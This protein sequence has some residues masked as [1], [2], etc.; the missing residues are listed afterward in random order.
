MY[1]CHCN[2]VTDRTVDAAIASGASTVPDITDRCTAGGG[3]GGC[4]RL[5]EELLEAS[6][7][8]YELAAASAA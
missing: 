6:A 2:G 5:L 8:K 4:H 7:A 3:C 1:V